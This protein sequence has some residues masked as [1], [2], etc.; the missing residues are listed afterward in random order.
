MGFDEFFTLE[1][2]PYKL[3][4]LS[5]IFLFVVKLFFSNNYLAVFLNSLLD[6]TFLLIIYCLLFI[7]DK[8]IISRKESTRAWTYLLFYVLFLFNLGVFVLNSFF[9]N[10]S[11]VMK[12]SLSNFNLGV[13]GFFFKSLIPLKYFILGPII[14]IAILALSFIDLKKFASI[15]SYLKKLLVLI[16]LLSIV[17]F[18]FKFDSVS[19]IYVTT[20]HEK[21]FGN[22]IKEIALTA[23]T[24][25]ETNYSSNLFDKQIRNYSEHAL[26]KNQRVLMFV[27][28]QTSYKTFI[29]DMNKIPEDQN[30]FKMVKPRTNIFTNHYTNDQD[31]MTAIWTMLNSNFIPYECYMDNWN[32]YYGFVL[33]TNDLVNLFNRNGYETNAV[34]SVYTAGLIMGIY[35]WTKVT[36]LKPDRNATGFFCPEDFEYEKGCEDKIILEDVKSLINN[37]NP[38]GLFMVQEFIYG[39]GTAYEERFHDTR[40]KYYNDYLLELYGYLK[41]NNLLENTTIVI[42]ADHGEKGYNEKQLWNYQT[43]LMIINEDLNYSEIDGLYSTS[44]FKDILLSYLQKTPLKKE[45]DF[46]YFVGQTQSSEIG[47]VDREGNYFLAKISGD[48]SFSIRN[49][50]GMGDKQIEEK[51]NIFEKYKDD[52][53]AKSCVKNYWCELCQQNALKAGIDS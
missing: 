53:A 3:M 49:F 1:H 43:P 24:V 4:L 29:E 20:L 26:P 2:Y 11:I 42:L 38:A 16:A 5:G 27:L 36:Y 44:D 18:L 41:Q 10:D 19:N 30:F 40:T 47:Y 32:K 35:N 39:H 33:G 12:Y 52:S 14:L 50:R 23:K 51:L 7:A 22:S 31:S 28:E 13:I 8:Q 45:E 21:F 17:I 9:F 6:F 37:S 48:N 46:V 15:E 34:S 25:S